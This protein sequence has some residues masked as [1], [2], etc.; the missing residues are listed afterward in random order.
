MGVISQSLHLIPKVVQYKLSRWNLIKPPIPDNL[1]FSVT[2][3]C[4][5]RCKTCNIWRLYLDN[6]KLKEKEL[7]IDEI[8][9]IFKNVGRQGN[10]YFFNISG[11]E[12]FLRQDLPEIVDAACK[13][14]KPKVIHT[15][16]NAILSDL[17]LKQTRK[18]LE[19]MKKNKCDIPFTIKPSFDGIGKEHDEIRGIKGNFDNFLKTYKGLKKLQ[20]EF[21]NL[22]VG[23][24]TV[25]S[26][27]NHTRIKEIMKYGKSLKP[28]SY[29]N[30]IA[31]QRSE[32]FTEKDEITPTAQ[33]YK[34]AIKFFSKEIRKDMKNKKPLVRITQAFRLVYYNLVVETLKRKTQVIPCYGGIASVHINAYG[35]VWPCCIL[36]YHKSMGNLREADYNFKKIWYSK[37]A[38]KI[39]RFIKNKKCHCPLANISYTNILC[40]P[41]YMIRVLKNVLF[42]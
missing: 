13:Y 11:G 25:I 42:P 34:K 21:P 5:S 18:I 4:Q 28:D 40:N 37:K 35:D 19:V 15:P 2:H 22:D 26:Q 3:A 6:P 14:L 8:R 39:R 9:K 38:D 12:P 36:G 16:T 30:E 24:G 17:I 29:I 41:K 1:T 31:E 32:L 23:I 27:F 10:V 20:K 33:E 7:K